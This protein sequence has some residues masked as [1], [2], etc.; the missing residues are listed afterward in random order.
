MQTPTHQ[1][2]SA[3][4]DEQLSAEQAIALVKSL[5]SDA[6]LDATL[7]RYQLIGDVIKHDK[8]LALRSDFA[9]AIHDAI[10]EQPAYLLPRNTV[11]KIK[12]LKM[13]QHVGMALAASLT[14]AVALGL[15]LETKPTS[16]FEQLAKHQATEMVATAVNPRLQDYLQ[17]HGA[18]GYIN[19]KSTESSYLQNASYRSQ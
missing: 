16:R 14:M 8:P 13:V 10:A 1:K 12:P 18:T 11:H 2:L 6:A 3:F 7:Q 15:T 5:R 4:C 9:S 17:A 19:S